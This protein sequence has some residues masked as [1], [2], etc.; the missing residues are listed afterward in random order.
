MN[1]F[2]DSSLSPLHLILSF[3]L[4]P[5]SA[6]YFFVI[7]FCLTSR[8]CGLL[9]AGCRTLV[10]ASDVCY[11]VSE[12]ALGAKTVIRGEWATQVAGFHQDPLSM[13]FSR[14]EH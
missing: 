11:L 9:S 7:S 10:L 5:S 1:S 4:A 12:V 6:T 2:S 14:Q 3:Y 13:G 8:V